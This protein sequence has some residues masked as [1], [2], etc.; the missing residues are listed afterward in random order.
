MKKAAS[1]HEPPEL[2]TG[3][4]PVPYVEE[5]ESKSSEL[6]SDLIIGMDPF[7]F[8]ELVA[9][10]LRAMGYAAETTQDGSDFGVDIVAH[11][12]E[13]GFENPVI[14]VQVKRVS[15]RTGNQD[16]GRFL[17]TF[18]H[19]ENGLFVSTGGYTRPATEEVRAAAQW[20]TLLD[21]DGFIDLLVDNY[22]KLEQEY[23]AQ[24]PLKQVY[25]PA[26]SSGISTLE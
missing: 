22:D 8:E 9:A 6:I 4:E 21:R 18:S 3:E 16:I 24:I 7:D 19:D 11:P 5:V 1:G 14:K 26:D 15:E 10:V 17:G 23:R 13:L 12:D 2:P 20:V 25:V